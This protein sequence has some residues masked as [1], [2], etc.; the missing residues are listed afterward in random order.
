[1]TKIP[2]LFELMESR[3]VTAQK[4]SQ[5]TGIS[6]GNI[7]DWKS[8]RSAPTVDKLIIL[9]NYFNVSIDYILGKEQKN[10]SSELTENE[11][12]IIELFKELSETQQGELIGRAKVMAEQ[13][14]AE[15]E[16]EDIG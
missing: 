7:S 16:K 10:S 5:D 2:K 1:M 14:A 11:L 12:T 9:S 15:Y 3:N 6:S 8:G 4:V 13:N